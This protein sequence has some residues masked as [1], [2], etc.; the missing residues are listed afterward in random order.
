M[1]SVKTR[2]VEVLALDGRDT[3]ISYYNWRGRIERMNIDLNT[4]YTSTI[5]VVVIMV[6]TMAKIYLLCAKYHSKYSDYTYIIELS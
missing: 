3:D 6:V 1:L 4:L 2:G 5:D